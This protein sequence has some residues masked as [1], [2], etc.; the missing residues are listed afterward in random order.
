M[1]YQIRLGLALLLCFA[2]GCSGSTPPPP[3]VLAFG[4]E[5]AILRDQLAI[6]GLNWAVVRNGT[7]LASQ[8]I[9]HQVG[10]PDKPFT[11]E[12]SL[13]IA[14]VTKSLTAVMVHQ[15]VDEGKLDLDASVLSFFPDAQV[16]PEAKVR[17]LLS[18]TSEGYPGKEYVYGTGRYSMLGPIIEQVT[19]QSFEEALRERILEPAGMRWYDSPH[20]GSHA[21]LVATAHELVRYVQ[22]LDAGKLT[23]EAGSQRLTSVETTPD[24][25]SLPTTLGWFAQEIQGTPVA[26]SY[27][28]D[29]PEHSGALLLRVPGQSLTLILLA[30]HN[31][32][33][34]P[35]RLLMGD[36]RKSPFAMA[37]FRLFV[38]SGE[39]EPLAAPDWS[40][41]DL[42]AELAQLEAATDYRYCEELIGQAIVAGWNGDGERSAELLKLAGE[43]YHVWDTDDLVLH[44]IASQSDDP[45]I[46][47]IG[48]NLGNRL[49]ER[50]PD[51]RWVLLA[52]GELHRATGHDALA[53]ASYES[54]L[55]LPNQ[56]PDFL[57]R[58]FKVWSWGARAE[59]QAETQPDLAR[60]NLRKVLDSGVGGQIKQDAKDL[61]ESLQ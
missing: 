34:D 16:S 41:A 40:A 17:H 35:F 26:W 53:L 38:A 28:Q 43:R 23:S 12:T 42:T 56:H 30:G 14:S 11:I 55:E 6:P 47:E 61:L 3:N 49:T 57:D 36:V 54:I 25:R 24:G 9:G 48:W 51:N 33:S 46:R 2:A 45:E 58:M 5:V 60:S 7:V 18:H 10:E 50:H 22:A 13:R 27:G 32:V 29:D 59:I 8:G 4:E 37:F 1:N 39:E 20:L 52:Q 19:E 15:L 44:F 21:G 31:T